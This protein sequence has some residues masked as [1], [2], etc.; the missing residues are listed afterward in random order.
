M[1]S[2]IEI[3]RKAHLEPIMDVG[4]KLDI[5]FKALR[6]YGHFKAKLSLS[7]LENKSENKKNFNYIRFKRFNNFC[8]PAR[9]ATVIVNSNLRNHAKT[10]DRVF[11]LREQLNG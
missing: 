1:S 6:P 11:K 9:G 2:D 7:W 5:P 8:A 3:A 10:V 4:D